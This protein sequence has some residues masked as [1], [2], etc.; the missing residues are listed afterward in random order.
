M[1]EGDLDKFY[2]A[3]SCLTL[4]DSTDGSPPGSSVQ[5]GLSRQVCWSG[6]PCPPSGELPNPG[7]ESMS[8]KSPAL[9]DGFFAT[10]AT[11]DA[12]SIPGSGRSPGEGNDY[13]LQYSCLENPMD[14]G[15]WQAAV[16]SIEKSQA[17]LKQLST[18]A[19]LLN[20][21]IRPWVQEMETSLEKFGLKKS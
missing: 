8:L 15:A 10:S 14:R 21:E 13:P 3:Q 12:G 20:W 9:A 5:G 6:L 4:C 19:R 16:Q 11:W 17:R 7:T 1:Q 2:A 18:H